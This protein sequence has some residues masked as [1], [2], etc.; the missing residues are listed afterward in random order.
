VDVSGGAARGA[1][2]V[3]LRPGAR[4]VE[5][6][7][8]E[9]GRLRF[10]LAE[11]R[12][13]RARAALVDLSNVDW[14]AARRVRGEPGLEGRQGPPGIDGAE[15]RQG[16]PGIPGIPGPP[17]PQG[18]QGE[19]GFR[20]PPGPEGERGLGIVDA[21]IVGTALVFTYTD[22]REE[23]V[24]RVVGTRGPPGPPGDRGIGSAAGE[25][26]VAPSPPLEEIDGGAW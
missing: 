15:G 1:G 26:G 9:R 18:P 14:L 16:D 19:R 2:R 20:G 7:L 25:G 17:G 24:G 3:T 23:N 11:L 4:R 6:A 21:R 5:L 22:G 13:L 12:R 10:A 8:G